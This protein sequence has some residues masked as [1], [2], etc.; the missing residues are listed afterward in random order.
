MKGPLGLIDWD[1]LRHEMIA[2]T[3]HL[4]A[5]RMSYSLQSVMNQVLTERL[6][7]IPVFENAQK[8]VGWRK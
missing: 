6:S 3:P 4:F 7:R 1:K 2:A 8:R 5:A